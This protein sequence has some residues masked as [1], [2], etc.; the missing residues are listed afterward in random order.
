MTSYHTLLDDVVNK[1]IKEV[2][3]QFNIDKDALLSLWNGSTQS[4]TP[5]Q[6]PIINKT[7][8]TELSKCSKNELVELC[9]SRSLKYSGTKEQLIAILTTGEKSKVP[10][11]VPNVPQVPLI[12]PQNIIQKLQN[13]RSSVSIKRNKFGNYEHQETS[14]VMDKITQKIIGKQ[15]PDGTVSPLTKEDIQICQ[16]HKL[17]YTIPENLDKKNNLNNIT[18][19]GLDD[20]DEEQE[21]ETLEDTDLLEE[22]EVVVEDDEELEEEVEELEED[23]DLV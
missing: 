14:L 7:S 22:A 8:L 9:K 3:K 4:T 21:E 18:I 16:Q 20:D 23:R 13:I 10:V 19:E 6:V 1:Y 17:Q 5:Q 11:V 2:S 12:Q 15:N